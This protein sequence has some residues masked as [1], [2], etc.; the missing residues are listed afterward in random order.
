MM[1]RATT[2]A[3]AGLRG[4]QILPPSGRMPSYYAKQVAQSVVASSPSVIRIDNQVLV[5][6][7]PLP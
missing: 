2:L 4:P 3:L 7:L 6:D 1:V 5:A